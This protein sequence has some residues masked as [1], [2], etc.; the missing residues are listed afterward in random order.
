MW[1]HGSVGRQR[2]TVP[3]ASSYKMPI[4]GASADILADIDSRVSL[5]LSG[6]HSREVS[7]LLLYQG[8]V[9]RKFYRFEGEELTKVKVLNPLTLGGIHPPLWYRKR[10][11]LPLY[12]FF[13][14]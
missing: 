5:S 10:L 13:R 1:F 6:M 12:L 8:V 7:K 4:G 11:C 9:S 3:A 14:G 2:P